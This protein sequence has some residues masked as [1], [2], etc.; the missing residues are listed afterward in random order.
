[1]TH[2]ACTRARSTGLDRAKAPGGVDA[3]YPSDLQGG[4]DAPYHP[5]FDKSQRSRR[6]SSQGPTSARPDSS[7]KAARHDVTLKRPLSAN[8]QTGIMRLQPHAGRKYQ[9]HPSAAANGCASG[10]SIEERC[11]RYSDRS[12]LARLFLSHTPSPACRRRPSFLTQFPSSDP[13]KPGEG[14]IA[15]GMPQHG[16]TSSQYVTSNGYDERPHVTIFRP[17]A[18]CGAGRGAWLI[19]V[20]SRGAHQCIADLAQGRV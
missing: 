18:P 20:P 17:T 19:R 3:P 8:E 15:L 16:F 7:K 5:G 13:G 9:R 4:V 11:G 1:M 10:L 14:A 6:A 2:D 12:V